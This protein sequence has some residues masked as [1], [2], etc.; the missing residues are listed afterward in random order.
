MISLM[1]HCNDRH[2][3]NFVSFS[4][5]HVRL[6]IQRLP[7]VFSNLQFVKIKAIDGADIDGADIG[8]TPSRLVESEDT[9]SSAESVPG[10][11]F[12]FRIAAIVPHILFP[13]D[14]YG[15]L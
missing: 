6:P 1:R 15:V 2:V 12:G 9:T 4:I 3:K 5:Q 11:L 13:L 14:F 7:I 10:S 8:V